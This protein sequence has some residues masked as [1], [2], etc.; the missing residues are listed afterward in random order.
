[1]EKELAI[2]LADLSGFTALTEAH[3]AVS[4]ADIIDRYLQIV[5]ESLVGEARLHERVGDEVVIISPSAD[6]ALAT[7][8]L[9]LKKSA[10]A[11]QFLQLHGGLHYGPLLERRGSYFGAALNFTSRMAS[12]AAAGSFLCSVPFIEALR[13]PGTL[14]FEKKGPFQFKNISDSFELYEFRAVSSQFLAIDPICRML[15]LSEEAAFPHPKE[16]GVYFCSTT[17]LEKYD[18]VKSKELT[19]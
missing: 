18:A 16:K 7:A 15:L 10:E 13:D 19:T 17:C 4:A 2:I 5:R 11:D 12:Q 14:H 1:M 3:G 6:D 9:M 8:M